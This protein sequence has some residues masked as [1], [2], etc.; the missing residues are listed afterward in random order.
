MMAAVFKGWSMLKRLV[1]LV[2]AVLLLPA[3]AQSQGHSGAKAKLPP[4]SAQAKARAATDLTA[5]LQARAIAEAAAQA[6]A[7]AAVL[8][9]G[10]EQT[11]TPL[12][13]AAPLEKVGPSFVSAP[14]PSVAHSS[15]PM[16][17]LPAWTELSPQRSDTPDATTS[18]AVAPVALSDSDSMT[19]DLAIAQQIH[20]G[21]MPCEMGA[22]VRVQADAAAPGYFHVQG[23][24]FRYRMYPVRT[25]T[26]ALRLED[27]KAGAV[28]LQLANKSM[29][30]DQKKGRRLADDCAHPEQVAYGQDMKTN[31]QPSL[32]DKTGTGKSND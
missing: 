32:F 22:S 25:S 24:G 9:Q 20:Q 29:L 5:R 8:N 31:P 11:N 3:W 28:W 6:A 18:A 23:K 27:K 17:P 1:V 19:Q 7:V 10:A 26:G 12:T 2:C 21:L 4:T 13:A 15:A 16:Q 14:Q 30:M